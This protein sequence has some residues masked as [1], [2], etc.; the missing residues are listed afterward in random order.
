MKDLLVLNQLLVERK[1]CGEELTMDGS[2]QNH[3]QLFGG[4]DNG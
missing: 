4:K 1:L 3:L 2:L